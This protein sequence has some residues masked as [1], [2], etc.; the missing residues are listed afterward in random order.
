M[1]FI[2]NPENELRLVLIHDSNR[3]EEHQKTYLGKSHLNPSNIMP[4]PLPSPWQRNILHHL[5]GIIIFSSSLF[6]ELFFQMLD[7][8]NTANRPSNTDH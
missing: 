7:S 3:I 2:H 8:Q 1:A 6:P 4:S 5:Q